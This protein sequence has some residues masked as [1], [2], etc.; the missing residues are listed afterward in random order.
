VSKDEVKLLLAYAD[1]SSL[2]ESE[3]MKDSAPSSAEGRMKHG[4]QFL[5]FMTRLS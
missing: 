2:L 1:L 3:K 5:S 4:N